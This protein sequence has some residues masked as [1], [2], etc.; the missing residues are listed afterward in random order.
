MKV[1]L[2]RPE[3]KAAKWALANAL[4]G[5][6]PQECADF[7]GSEAQAKAADRAY[8]KLLAASYHPNKEK[9][10]RKEKPCDI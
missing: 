5:D 4:K 7:F 10:L 2:T 6:D 9:K 1:E 8:Q 3:I